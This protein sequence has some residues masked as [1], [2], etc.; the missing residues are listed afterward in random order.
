MRRY[1]D[2]R[3]RHIGVP[4]MWNRHCLPRRAAARCRDDEEMLAGGAEE[5]ASSKTQIALHVLTTVNA[6]EFP[7]TVGRIQ[8]IHRFLA[9]LFVTSIG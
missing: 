7:A 9:L 2:A 6:V 4:G 8:S 3:E 5:L 1:F